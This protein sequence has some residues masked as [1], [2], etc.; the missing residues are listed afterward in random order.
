MNEVLRILLVDDHPMIRDGVARL[1][2]DEPG[3]A[4]CGEADT[5][6][7]ALTTA[8]RK[9][10]HVIL[11]DLSL[12]DHF[13]LSLIPD[14]L[15]AHPDGRVLVYSMHEEHLYAERCLRAGAMGYI[16]KNEPPRR[17]VEGLRAV[18]EGKV[19]VS[20]AMSDR[21]L[22]YHR[23][24]ASIDRTNI[25]DVLT[26][27]ELEVFMC[28]GRGMATRD[29]AVRLNLSR[30]T[31]QTHREHIKEKLALDSAAELAHRA[32]DW[33]KENGAD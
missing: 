27:R 1:I 19:F 10:P 13:A 9:R 28:I 26:D 20:A 29:I 22:N 33:V 31:V 5:P 7:A 11:L 30:K 12:R 16:M 8:E 21:L 32:I 6:G 15:R 23:G 2:N 3:M 25:A 24:R 4:V 18:A 14:L 17:L